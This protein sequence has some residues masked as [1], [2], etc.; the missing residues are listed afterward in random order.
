MNPHLRRPLIFLQALALAIATLALTTA[1]ATPAFASQPSSAGPPSTLPNAVPSASTPA[2]DNGR[3]F[4]IAQVGNTMVIGGSFTSVGGQTRNRVAAFNTSTGALSATFAPSVNGDVN[5]VLPGPNDHTVYIGGNFTQVGSRAAQFV[6]LL[7]LNNGS[8]LSSFV[9]PAFNYGFVN[10]MVKRG[11]R[12]YVAGTFTAVG[13]RQHSGLV[14]LNATTGALDPFVNVQ[15]TGHHN[16]TGSGAQGWIG[17]W[18]LDVTPDGNT[19]VATGNFKYADELLRDQIVMVDL[20]GGTAQVSLGWST[21]RYAPQCYNWAFD[22]YVRGVSFSPDGSYFVTNATGGG[23]GGTLCDA[24]ARWETDATGSD[25]QPTWVNETGGDTAWGVTV[26]DT[27]VYVGGH[28]RWSNNPNGVDQAQA[29]AVPR[30]GL[31]ALDPVSGRPFTWNPGRR[32]LGV[33]VFAM[34][35]TPE[36]LWIG[37]NN[38]YIGNYRYRRPKLAFFPYAGGYTPASTETSGLP[39]TVYL[40]GT[41]AT[42]QSNV[43]YRVNAGGSDIQALDS[44]PDWAADDIDP[45][46]FRNGGSNAAGW[47]PGA[48]VDSSVPATTPL[49]VFDSERWSPSDNP[50]MNWAFPVQD[51]LPL[52]IRLYFAN[53]C[54]CTDEAGERSFNV[55]LDGT[56]VLE[57]YDIVAEVGDQRG[58]MKTFNIAS[59]GTVNIDF[60]HTVENPLINAIEILRTDIAPP[61]PS[62]TDTLSTVAFDG[63]TASAAPGDGQGIDF[64]N[65]RGAVKIGG[66]VFYGYTDNFLYSRTWDGTR[67]GPAVKIDPYNDPAWSDVQTDLGQTFRGA[68]PTLYGQMPNVT[69]MFYEDGKLYYTLFGDSALHWRWFSPDSGIVD[70]RNATVPSS[71]SFGAASGMFVDGGNLYY[72]SRTDGA[73]RRV[74]FDGNE[75]SGGATVVS[76]P[77]DDGVNWSNRAMFLGTGTSTPANQSPTARFS[78][79]CTDLSCSFDGSASTDG[80]GTVASYAWDFGDGGSATG[81]TPPAHA[82]ATPGTYT[83]VLTVTDDRDATGSVSHDVTVTAANQSPTARFSSSC[84]DLSCSFDGSAS[85]DSDGTVASY[86]WDFGDGGTATGKTPPAHAYATPGTY[87]VAL[88]VTDDR[89]AT[90]SVSHDVTATAPGTGSLGFVA[91]AHGPGG[92]RRSQQL[93]VPNAAQSGD[94][95]LLFLARTTPTTWTGPTGVTGWTQVGTFANGS[96]TTTVW[97]KTV[98]P[99]DSG[100]EVRVD[101]TVYTHASLNL[102]VY[103]GVDTADPIAAAT[104]VGETSRSTHVTPTVATSAGNWVV[105]YWAERSSTTT[106]WT[107]PADVQVRDESSD[108]NT[109]LRVSALLSDSG[110]PVGPGSYGG[111]SA[112]TDG[113]SDRAVMWSIA[114]NAAS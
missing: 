11:N 2:V 67:F 107:A 52:Q 90:G 95:M 71:V 79:T 46:A 103:S 70:E 108:T 75:V 8:V 20:S 102:V 22:G 24:T 82:Y 76:G 1:T 83:V 31:G 111:L 23:V 40:G 18:D 100:A 86:A 77:D 93:T 54:T 61:P 106:D 26:T 6:S 14:S 89:N 47:S 97:R 53:R 98:A 84:T 81:K 112:T 96:L 17:P 57:N 38:D 55:S 4:G 7:D 29:G 85:T 92:N 9:T 65:W 104:Q 99:G 58:T 78:S 28:N 43:L 16:D 33:A 109:A 72:A 48:I 51:G 36:G 50:A 101:T 37:S 5:A 87:T 64:G 114:L 34:L 27:A 41:K 69:G 80:D 21:S 19:M 35:A 62:Q 63:T 12:L 30:P 25:V 39:G 88:T 113:T 10:D 73:L 68:V 60:T 66:Q 42:G 91:G 59:D 3:V 110:G 15:L 49:G 94:T 105:S 45:S 13:G 74:S 56:R 32:P 44:G